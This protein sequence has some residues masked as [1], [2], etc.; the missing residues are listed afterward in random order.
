MSNSPL[1]LRSCTYP[2]ANL[3]GKTLSGAA[4]RGRH[5]DWLTWRDELPCM[6][7]LLR[8]RR[9]HDRSSLPPAH[10]CAA[11]PP[12]PRP[13]P[14]APPP[15]G[16]LMSEAQFVG[17]N[18]REV[19]LSKAYAVGASLKGADLTNAV[20]DRVDFDGADLSGARFVNA[21]ITGAGGGVGDAGR[22]GHAVGVRWWEKYRCWVM[23]AKKPTVDHLPLHPPPPHALQARP[24]RA[25]TWQARCLRTR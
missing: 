11:T 13:R 21:V 9:R 23:D 22:G 8:S 20:V 6:L 17:A 4:G 24:L 15:A 14:P 12:P 2:G 1:D 19:V 16:A 18:M 3:S 7:D 10:S 5:E 25:P